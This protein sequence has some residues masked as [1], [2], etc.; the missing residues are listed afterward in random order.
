MLSKLF[1]Q[2]ALDK[3]RFQATLRRY[4]EAAGYD[5]WHRHCQAAYDGPTD[6]TYPGDPGDPAGRLDDRGVERVRV[7]EPARAAD[8][9]SR[10]RAGSRGRLEAKSRDYEEVFEIADRPLLDELFG[11]I[12]AGPLDAKI[13]SWF[14][15]HYLIYWWL[16]GRALPGRTAERSFLWHCDKGPS[17]HLKL[18]VYLNPSAAHRGATEFLDRPATDAI[19]ETGYIFGRTAKRKGDLTGLARAHGIALE[20]IRFALD[21]GEAILFQPSR[22]LHKGVLPEHGERWVLAFCLLPSPMPWAIVHHRT[23]RAG[24]ARDFAWHL[25]AQALADQIG[26][27]EDPTTAN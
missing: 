23:G 25:Q 22:V 12:F 7:L 8:A 18:L 3:R 13:T 11:A 5:D 15:S 21:A 17:R 4:D 19:A 16:L 14:A 26:M 6:P 20:P 27:P 2:G 24:P 1:G 10:L 9:L